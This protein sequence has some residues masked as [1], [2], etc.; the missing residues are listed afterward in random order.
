M[1]SN[2]RPKPVTLKLSKK[3]HTPMLWFY[4]VYDRRVTGSV[5]L[6]RRADRREKERGGALRFQPWLHVSILPY[7]PSLHPWRLLS[8][9]YKDF[10]ENKVWT[11]F[12]ETS[13]MQGRRFITFPT[14]FTCLIMVI[15]IAS[16]ELWMQIKCSSWRHRS[17]PTF[18]IRS[19]TYCSVLWDSQVLH[20]SQT[21]IVSE[22]M[23]TTWSTWKTD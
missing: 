22:G 13:N 12:Y 6:K 18:P 14:L 16:T 10:T 1:G 23:E 21:T 8:A 11:H 17:K 20:I 7:D 15:W 19:L 4:S 3:Q 5:D 9:C 2:S